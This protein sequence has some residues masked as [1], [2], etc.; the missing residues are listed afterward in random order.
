MFIVMHIQ[1]NEREGEL[2]SAEENTMRF[3]DDD[4]ANDNEYLEAE[5]ALKEAMSK[6]KTPLHRP[7]AYPLPVLLREL[8][9]GR[10]ARD[11]QILT[12][13]ADRLEDTANLEAEEDDLLA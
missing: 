13:L 10:P 4:D 6:D 2:L 5:A 1:L 3:T 11:Q 8:R 12:E 9:Y 7:S